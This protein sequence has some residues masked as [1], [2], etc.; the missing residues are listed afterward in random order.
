MSVQDSVLKETKCPFLPEW[1]GKRDKELA[2]ISGIASLRFCHKTGFMLTADEKEDA[3]LA[4]RVSREKEKNCEL[5][6]ETPILKGKVII[7]KYYNK[8]AALNFLAKKPER[9]RQIQTLL[10]AAAGGSF[11][12][13]LS[14]R[15]DKGVKTALAMILGGGASNLYDRVKKGH[16]VDYFSFKTRSRR[17]SG[18]IFNISDFFVFAGALLLVLFGKKEK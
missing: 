17:L 12:T 8:G 15:G 10:M 6:E 2:E 7:R 9:M 4:C 18:I 11:F 5:M 14:R 3:I 16:V 1:Y 13:L